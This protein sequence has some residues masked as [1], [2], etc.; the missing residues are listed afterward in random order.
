MHAIIITFYQ[1]SLV[2][3]WYWPRFAT[4][5]QNRAHHYLIGSALCAQRHLTP[6]AKPELQ[7]REFRT[8][9]INPA[10]YLLNALEICEEK[11]PEVIEL[12]ISLK[13]I[14]IEQD[15]RALLIRDAG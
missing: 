7:A 11:G 14:A 1:R 4:I 8:G 15:D 5:L 3:G 12:V 9:K 10:S 13:G 2:R 6:R